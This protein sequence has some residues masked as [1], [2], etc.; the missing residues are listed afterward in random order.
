M[1]RGDLA[2]SFNLIKLGKAWQSWFTFRKTVRPERVGLPPGDPVHVSM[3]VLPMG[4]LGAVDVMQDALRTVVY[5]WAGVNEDLEVQKS[6]LLPTESKYVFSYFD[7]LDVIRKTLRDFQALDASSTEMRN[8]ERVCKQKGIPMA[9]NKCMRGE[10]RHKILGGMVDGRR[11][12]VRASPEKLVDLAQKSISMVRTRKV[13]SLQLQ[14][15]GDWRA[16]PVA[17]AG[18]STASS[19]RFSSMP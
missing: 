3:N 12:D 14:R 6:K 2:S 17:S 5:Q 18:H 10:T 8:F 13:T 7:G 1:D 16:S 11:G 15:W 9:L 19:A 4:W